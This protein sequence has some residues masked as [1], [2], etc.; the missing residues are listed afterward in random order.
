MTTPALPRVIPLTPL[1]RRALDFSDLTQWMAHMDEAIRRARH[2]MSAMRA[3][4]WQPESPPTSVATP[5]DAVAVPAM[6]GGEEQCIHHGRSTCCAP[7]FSF[8]SAI[9][10]SLRRRSFSAR[11]SLGTALRR[12]K[13]AH[14]AAAQ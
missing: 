6:E 7:C 5:P 13:A 14:I 2:T 12:A 10:C 4:T 1:D 8:T 3:Q 9:S 11:G